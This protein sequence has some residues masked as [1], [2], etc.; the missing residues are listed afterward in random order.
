MKITGLD[1]YQIDIPI[2]EPK[3]FSNKT[4]SS[5]DNTV[6]CIRTDTKHVGWGEVCPIATTYQAEHALGVRAALQ[7]MA[8]GLMGLDPTHTG[9]VNE[10]M[11]NWL[12]GGLNAKSAIDIACWDLAAKSQDKPLYQLIG[13]AMQ[14]KAKCY[15][16]V[17][18]NDT[19]QIAPDIAAYR[20]KGYRHF[21]IKNRTSDVNLAIERIRT[22]AALIEPTEIMVVD[23]NKAWATHEAIRICR[24]TDEFDFYIEQPC[25]TYEECLSVRRQIRQPMILDE[26]MTD[27]G[28]VLRALADDA[29]EGIG[30]KITRVG[31]I[32]GTCLIR[33]VCRAAGKVLT[34]DDMWGADLSAAAQTHL[35]VS[36][37]ARTCLASYIST[38]FSKLRYDLNAPAM[39]DGTI[40]ANDKAG[41]GVEPSLDILGQPVARYN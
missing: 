12:M 30:C 1:L 29:F 31:G 11:N 20:A 10:A 24:V 27:I 37:S 16:A 6:V 18:L 4:Y 38:D 23:A 32:T 15:C 35:A 17:E 13:G 34:I 14:S 9:V 33:D 22:A 39:V 26:C 21:Q 7:E 8:P 41:L 5:F 2:N 25:L 36:S 28:V 40:V 3:T 19:E